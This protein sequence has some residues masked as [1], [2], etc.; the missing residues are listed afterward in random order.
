MS[1]KLPIYYCEKRESVFD[2]LYDDL[3]LLEGDNG[4]MYMHLFQPSTIHREDKY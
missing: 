1:F 4:G 2:N 3:E